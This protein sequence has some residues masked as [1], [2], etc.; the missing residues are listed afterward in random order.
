MKADP[1]RPIVDMNLFCK[2]C[3]AEF[4]FT[5]GEQKYFSSL[6]LSI[7]K[8]CPICRKKRRLSLVP[9]SEVRHDYR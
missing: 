4:T 7:P 3:G 1:N 6:D 9:D 2:E 5:V 8:R